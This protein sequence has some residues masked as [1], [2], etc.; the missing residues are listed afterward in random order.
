MNR[1]C[2]TFIKKRGE[3]DMNTGM[4]YFLVLAQEGSISAAAQRLYVS[5]QAFSEQMKR[6]EAAYGEVLFLRKPRFALTPAGQALLA[7]LRQIQ[8]LEDGLE[9]QLKEL[10]D[11]SVGKLRVGIHSTR[12][13][14]LL[15]PVLGQYRRL[16]PN[17]E[18]AFVHNDTLGLEHMLLNGELDLFFGVDARPR[19][20]FELTPLAQEP[21]LLAGRQSLFAGL[22][23]PEKEGAIPAG[24]LAALPLIFSPAHS[25]QQRKVDSFLAGQGLA[26]A[27]AA[28]LPDFELQLMLAAQ[29]MGACFCPALMLSKVEEL[30]AARPADPLVCRRVKGLEAANSLSLVTYKR[31]YHSQALLAFLEIFRREFATLYKES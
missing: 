10:R 1:P 19:P 21:I 26:L 25:N 13:R 14:V 30:N 31:T 3:K 17:V 6:L 5:Q 11:K 28:T 4:K 2:G 20:E 27:P 15:P 18:L 23:G 29:G 7:T 24:C 22:P 8:A 9:T 12:G 16:F